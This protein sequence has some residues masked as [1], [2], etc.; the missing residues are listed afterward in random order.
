M[1]KQ[2]T[3]QTTKQDTKE[4]IEMPKITEPKNIQAPKK[5]RI[6]KCEEF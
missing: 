1:A 2:T 5:N 6:P 4:P 3:K